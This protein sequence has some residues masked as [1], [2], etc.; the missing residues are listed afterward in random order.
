MS[1]PL[2]SSIPNTP[3]SCKDSRFGYSI[4]TAAEAHRFQ[5][6]AYLFWQFQVL[7]GIDTRAKVLSWEYDEPPTED[8]LLTRQSFLERIPAI[9][10]LHLSAFKD[11]LLSWAEEIYEVLEGDDLVGEYL[12]DL[13]RGRYVPRC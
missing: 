7:F 5:T 10:L 12:I 11:Y 13:T 1:I 6:S 4:L 2:P 3:S 9:S 8:R